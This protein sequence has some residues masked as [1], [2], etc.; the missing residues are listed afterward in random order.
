MVEFG[1]RNVAAGGIPGACPWV[2]TERTGDDGLL[3][4]L[5]WDVKYNWY[6]LPHKRP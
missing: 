1:L 3:P 4:I 2:L 5:L 6:V